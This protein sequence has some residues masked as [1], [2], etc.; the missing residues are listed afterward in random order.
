M[1]VVQGSLQTRRYI[2]R[3]GNKRTAYEVVADNVFFRKSKRNSGEHPAGNFDSQI[4]QFNETQPAF[5]TAEP[6]DFEE[7]VGDEELPF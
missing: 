6:G 1:I 4:P 5:S 7:I 3:D 2:D